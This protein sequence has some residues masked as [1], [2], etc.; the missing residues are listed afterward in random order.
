MHHQS[1]IIWVFV[2]LMFTLFLM[3]LSPSQYMI[4]FGVMIVPFLI[5]YQTYVVLRGA[6]PEEIKT[7]AEEK[8]YENE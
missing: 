4:G 8:W 7:G 1:L 6:A 5:V 3:F 2:L